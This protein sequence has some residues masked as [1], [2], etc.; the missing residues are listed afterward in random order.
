MTM[1]TRTERQQVRAF[2]E[3]KP[4][5]SV[6]A[7]APEGTRA[8]FAQVEERRYQLEPFIPSYADFAGARGKQLLEIG[9]GLG[10]DFVRFARAGAEATGIDLTEHAVA[11]LQRRLEIEGLTATVRVADAEHL[12]F[13]DNSFDRVYSWGVL[14][15][16]P[17]TRAALR[18]V[19]RVL[20]PGG[21]LCVM[22][23]SRTSWVA[24]GL[25]LRYALLAGRPWHGVRKVLGAHME[26]PGTKAFTR[27]EFE[28]MFEP[29]ADLRIEQVA[30]P[31]DRRVVGPLADWTARRMGWF[32]VVRGRVPMA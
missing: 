28:R 9:V 11:L 5:G 15:H 18:E 7:V 25:W 30:T 29:L 22:L 20:R 16:T 10:T 13:A 19:F 23:Y 24:Y 14:H 3:A 27:R 26:S 1:A 32:T 2:W 6:H 21:E 12:P 17:D 31:Y 8:Y 4:C